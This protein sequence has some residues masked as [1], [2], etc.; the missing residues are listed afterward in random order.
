MMEPMSDEERLARALV[1]N[2]TASLRELQGLTGI[3]KSNIAAVAARI[4]WKQDGKLWVHD[5]KA[6]Q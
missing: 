3:S 4:G 5:D 2:P 6:I 1:N